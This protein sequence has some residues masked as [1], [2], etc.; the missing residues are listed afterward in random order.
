MTL[1]IVTVSTETSDFLK[2][3]F[4]FFHVIEFH[5]LSVPLHW[6][7]T[8]E[9]RFAF[10]EKTVPVRV[11]VFERICHRRSQIKHTVTKI[12]FENMATPWRCSHAP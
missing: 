11:N 4:F 3:M 6:G 1:Q 5:V 9:E 7:S 8:L 10:L 12:T 2:Q